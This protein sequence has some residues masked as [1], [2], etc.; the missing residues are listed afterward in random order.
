MPEKY[1]NPSALNLVARFV[2][3]Q[4]LMVIEKYGKDNNLTDKQIKDI[5]NKFLKLNNIYP[6]VI[7]KKTIELQQHL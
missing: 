3:K 5:E 4:N 6:N 7:Q 1:I 2:K